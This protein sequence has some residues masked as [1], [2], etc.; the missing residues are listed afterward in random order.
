MQHP[1]SPVSNQFG[2]ILCG[3]DL[4]LQVWSAGPWG[5][6]D[7]QANTVYLQRLFIQYGASSF[8]LPT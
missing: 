1:M 7:A 6:I 4:R 3:Q 2:S 5:V 8:L